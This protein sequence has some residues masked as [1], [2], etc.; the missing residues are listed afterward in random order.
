MTRY[1]KEKKVPQK[2]ENDKKIVLVSTMIHQ[3]GR[4]SDQKIEKK[5]FLQEDFRSFGFCVWFEPFKDLFM[6]YAEIQIL[7]H[8]ILS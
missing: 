5:N 8:V 2:R 7:C 1:Q 4:K 6:R 3:D